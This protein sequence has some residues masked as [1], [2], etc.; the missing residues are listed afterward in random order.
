[1]HVCRALRITIGKSVL[2]FHRE[3][4]LTQF[5]RLV[6]S[7]FS[8]QIIFLAHCGLF[9]R[10]LELQ[11]SRKH[12]TNWAV[13]QSTF[14]SVFNNSVSQQPVSS[15]VDVIHPSSRPSHLSP[16]SCRHCY[17]WGP[18]FT[19]MFRWG[20]WQ[21]SPSQKPDCKNDVPSAWSFVSSTC[22]FFRHVLP[23]STL[24][25]TLLIAMVSY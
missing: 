18:S 20:E 23:V 3:R 1:M 14:H 11:S 25:L 16:T 15:R 6:A 10:G 13:F 8:H 21:P 19:I 2:S 12:I 7:A 9:Q 22:Y 5:A 17:I 24:S 4:N